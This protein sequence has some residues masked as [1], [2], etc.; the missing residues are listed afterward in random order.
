MGKDSLTL[1]G[2]ASSLDGILL[3]AR[4]STLDELHID[5]PLKTGYAILFVDPPFLKREPPR[6]QR[7]GLAAYDDPQCQLA[8][9]DVRDQSDGCADFSLIGPQP[10]QTTSPSGH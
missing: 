6:C 2:V 10:V 4:V 3:G 5:P 7:I 9:S 8:W 1:T